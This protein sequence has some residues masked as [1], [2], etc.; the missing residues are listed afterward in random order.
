MCRNMPMTS[1]LYRPAQSNNTTPLHVGHVGNAEVLVLEAVFG[2]PPYRIAARLSSGCGVA[3]VRGH[4][5][6]G[7]FQ[8]TRG[9]T[10]HQS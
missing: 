9:G 5:R 2:G 8:R 6:Q 1:F 10:Q 4:V 7:T 3:N